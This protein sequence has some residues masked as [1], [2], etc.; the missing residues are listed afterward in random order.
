MEMV[1]DWITLAQVQ[2][3]RTISSSKMEL[4]TCRKHERSARK[5]VEELQAANGQLTATY[6]MLRVRTSLSY[7]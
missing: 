3:R 1:A 7:R 4:E 5:K 6:H 2:L